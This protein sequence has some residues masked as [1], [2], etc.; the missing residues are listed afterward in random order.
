MANETDQLISEILNL[1][2]S[3]MTVTRINDNLYDFKSTVE[4]KGIATKIGVSFSGRASLDHVTKTVSYWD[5]IT[6]SSSGI[7]GENMG[8]SS[9]TYS[10]KGLERSGS[11][12]GAVPGGETYRYDYA[13]VREQVKAIVEKNGWKFKTT[14]IKPKWWT[15]FFG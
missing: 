6:K 12:S 9:E 1:N 8:Y 4:S 14:L 3:A 2:T 13:K 10:V 15:G 11:G 7:G 5:M